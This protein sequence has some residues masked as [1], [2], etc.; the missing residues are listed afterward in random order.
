MEELCLDLLGK[1]SLAPEAVDCPMTSRLYDPR[2]R[3]LRD[4]IG[5]PLLQGGGERFLGKLF[6]QIEISQKMDEGGHSAAPIR[7]IQCFDDGNGIHSH[8]LIIEFLCRRT[9]ETG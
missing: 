4:A 3:E 7:T 1:E 2:P 6:R 5:G 9:V 8:Y